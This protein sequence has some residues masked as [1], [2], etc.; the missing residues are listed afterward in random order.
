MEL[1]IISILRTLLMRAG[2]DSTVKVHE[3]RPPCSKTRA[4]VGAT[5]VAEWRSRSRTG[6]V[7]K[8]VYLGY[9]PYRPDNH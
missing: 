3:A 2:A 9:E 1:M 4:R 5:R 7:A 6:S 8:R